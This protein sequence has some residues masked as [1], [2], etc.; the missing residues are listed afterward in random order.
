MRLSRFLKG[1]WKPTLL[2]LFLLVASISYAALPEALEALAPDL[3]LINGKIVTVDKDFSIQQAVAVKN[4]GIIAVGRSRDIQQLAGSK[5]RVIDLKGKTVLPGINDAHTHF[6]GFGLSRPPAAL[7]VSSAS[8][9]SIA[10]IAVMAGR[11]AKEV[12]PGEWISG[13]G[14]DEGYLKECLED[15]GVRHPTCW[16]IDKQ[17]PDNPVCLVD[18]SGHNTWCNSKAL[19]LAKVTKNTP[20]PTGGEIVRDS[21]TGE[22]TGFFKENAQPLVRS[23]IPPP[24]KDQQIEALTVAMREMTAM[25]VTSI[26]DAS[27]SPELWSLYSDFYRKTFKEG[28][29]TIRVNLLLNWSGD[30]AAAGKADLEKAFASVGL[31]TGFGDNWLRVAGAKIVAD[32]IPLTK[33]AWMFDEYVGG[34]T[35]GLAIK[36]ETEQHQYDALI[37]MIR[38]LNRKRMQIGV[39]SCGDRAVSASVDGFVKA[40][41]EDPWDARHYVIHAD[42]VKPSDLQTMAEYDIGVC[43]QNQIMSKII[44]FMGNI[45]G[46]EK[47]ANQW[48]LGDFNKAGVW[49]TQSSDTPVVIPNWKQGMENCLLRE[50]MA[51]GKVF[52]PR[53]RIPIKEAIRQYTINSA[54]Q[55]HQEDIKGSIEPGKLADF[56]VLGEDILTID[57][58]KISGIPVLMTIVSGKIVFSTD[59]SIVTLK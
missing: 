22:P 24:S 53:H 27:V 5:T 52:G 55:D 56:V 20:D 45:A 18:F 34:G 12:K 59:K 37:E 8:V 11:R 36:G 48:P 43:T 54:Y 17:T 46:P 49:V 26:T 7:D 14:W 9:K 35:G 29:W 28:K 32:G 21:K 23:L 2:S 6:L 58:H 38:F 57:P 3:I 33:T 51:S 13:S 19:E 39:H 4:Q 15:P 42:F 44:E 10:E 47:S 50:S 1:S 25:G 16:D 41:R 30:G 31:S 40:L